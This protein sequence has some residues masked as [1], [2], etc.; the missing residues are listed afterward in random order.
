MEVIQIK[1]IS[2]FIS[3]LKKIK[4][5]LIKNGEEVWFRGVSDNSYELIPGTVWRKIKENNHTGIIEEWLNEY[6]LYSNEKLDDGFDIYALAQH[7][8]LPTRLLDWTA[9]PLVALYFALEKDEVNE[10]RV[11]WAID[12]LALNKKMVD[13]DGHLSISDRFLRDKYKLDKYLPESLSGLDK[14]DLMAGPVSIRVQ[15]RNRRLISQKGCFTIHG[16][17]K[18]LLM[19]Y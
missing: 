7:Y 4:N 1:S 19:K 18:K 12:P 2:G 9:S 6:L 13:W 3:S 15:P 8:G 10:K 5:G 17:S 11:V 16:T 14:S